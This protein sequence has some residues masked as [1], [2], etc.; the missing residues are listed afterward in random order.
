LSLS[1]IVDNRVLELIEKEVLSG[2]EV[3]GEI[4][5]GID[6]LETIGETRDLVKDS[7]VIKDM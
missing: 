6:F 1:E 5:E 2:V 4:S 7:W 3:F